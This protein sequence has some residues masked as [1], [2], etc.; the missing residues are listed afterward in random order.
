LSEKR[1]TARV[2]LGAAIPIMMLV[3]AVCFPRAEA[4]PSDLHDGSSSPTVV[5]P[6]E[7]SPAG[8]FLRASISGLRSEQVATRGGTFESLEIPGEGVTAQV[9]KPK[10]PV[11]RRLVEIPF[12]ATVSVRVSSASVEERS[13]EDMALT[14]PIAPVQAPVPKIPGA[15]ERSAFAMD[16]GHYRTDAFWPPELIQVKTLGVLRETRL[17][18]VEIFPVRYNPGAGLVQICSAVDF[19]LSFEGADR[20]LTDA[21]KRR[22][23]NRFTAQWDSSPMF[24]RTEPQPSPLEGWTTAPV[25]YLMVVDD[26]LR[27]AALP[28]ADLKR[29]QGFQVTLVTTAQAGSD[30]AEIKSYIQDAY[31]TWEIPPTF[32]L[33]VGDADRLP[34]YNSGGRTTDLFYTTMSEEDYFPDIQV[35]RLSAT[36]S[37]QLAGVVSKIVGYER[38]LWDVGDTW[39]RRGYFMASNDSW[40]HQV[41]EGT[42]DYAMRTARAHGMICDSLYAYY[43]TG[44]PV[45]QAL[46]GG[47][48]MAV[49]SGHGSFFSWSGPGFVKSDVQALQNGQMYP[50]VCSHACNTGGFQKDECFGETW[51]RV[52][53]RGAAAFWGSSVSSYWDEDDILERRMFDALFDDTITWL[54]GMMDKAKL[55]LWL[56]YGGEGLSKNYYEQYNLLGDPSMHLWIKPPKSLLVS[57][58][59]QMPLGHSSFLVKVHEPLSPGPGAQDVIQSV[60]LV[61]V[62]GA[63]TSI[64]L[65]G[66]RY[67][68]ADT[69]DGVA[70]V[71]LDTPP[72]VEGSL[73]VAVS[74]MGYRAYVGSAQVRAS[75]P[76]IKYGGHRVDDAAG[77]NGD[78]QANAGETIQ[79]EI[80]LDNV[81]SETAHRLM[82]VLIVDDPY[83][84]I[85]RSSTV[86]GNIPA[87]SSGVGIPPYEC[88]IS[89]L[90]P[91]GH[92]TDFTIVAKD[93][94]GGQWSSRF[95][96]QVATPDLRVTEYQIL[97]DSPNGNGNGTAEFGETIDLH[98]TLHNAGPGLAKGVRASLSSADAHVQ[99]LSATSLYGDMAADSRASG[100]PAYRIEIVGTGTSLLS[101]PLVLDVATELGYASSDTLFLPVG[102]PGFNDDIEA[103]A[104]SWTHADIGGESGDH[105]HISTEKSHSGRYS[106]KC[107][108]VGDGPYF[109]YQNDALT[110]GPILLGR[111]SILSFWH[112]MEAEVYSSVDAWDGGVVEISTDGGVNWEQ[113][114][115][116]GGYPCTIWDSAPSAGSPFAAGTPCFSGSHDWQEERFDLSA[117]SGTVHVRFRFGSDQY[118]EKEGWYIDDVLIVSGG[119]I[120]R[121]VPDPRMLLLSGEILLFWAPLTG[122]Q[123]HVSYEIYRSN[124]PTDVVAQAHLVGVVSQPEYVDRLAGVDKDVQNLYYVVV[125]VD[126]AGWRSAPSPVMGLLRRAL[127]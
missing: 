91:S 125:A 32:L 16:R 43:N 101:C 27:E 17:A 46:N 34:A 78:G 22:Y 45:S 7:S 108:D 47:R 49:Y 81:G 3:L 95:Q 106:W 52:E 14:E 109:R 60:T 94:L 107:G 20:A 72:T 113:I 9:G 21:H 42:Q 1:I 57:H 50:L 26:A 102:T 8:V 19:Q 84:Q 25:G 121:Y 104:G 89:A 70:S 5:S 92:E 13:L 40:Y 116:M 53:D 126:G 29:Q 64:S 2:A 55:E 79:L 85:G 63:L 76:Y 10:L 31:Q 98:V 110:N 37:S 83:V 111:S 15:A 36:D 48:A 41:A 18:L 65:A 82:A 87:K 54:S 39:T 90:Y 44:T 105:W 77:G 112:W 59:D 4:S 96:M 66:Q 99:I 74:K 11:V 23:G 118:S 35:G 127:Q 88:H 30:K 12:G 115:P 61:P 28:L 75:G 33:L 80:T 24:I 51:L 97:D 124:R 120:A 38:S 73:E 122:Q 100:V 71:L 67:G 58:A 103:G 123:E 114:A 56:Y 119:S 117:Y 6:V 93:S 62:D 68:L 69:R 86:F